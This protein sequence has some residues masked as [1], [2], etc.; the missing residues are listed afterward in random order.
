[1]PLS[2]EP[3]PDPSKVGFDA[4]WV[5]TFLR[6][7]AGE[8]D[9]ANQPVTISRSQYGGEVRLDTAASF[10]AGTFEIKI[11]GLSD[12]DFCTLVH[13]GSPYRLVQIELGWRDLGSGLLAPFASLAAMVRQSG[14]HPQRSLVMVGRIHEARRVTGEF[15]YV[16]EFSGVDYRFHKLS[17][18]KSPGLQ[19][20]EQQPINQYVKQLCDGIIPATLHPDEKGGPI[21]EAAID[22]KSDETVAEALQRL[23]RSAHPDGP[24]REIPMF[25]RSDGLHFGAWTAP[26]A[27]SASHE[28]NLA[29]GLVAS[30]P[31]A[32]RPASQCDVDPFKP[33]QGLKYRL[34]LL[35]RA[36]IQLGDLAKLEPQ[37][38]DVSSTV[39]SSRLGPL[40][41]AVQG[42]ASLFSGRGG[43]PRYKDFRVVGV[44]HKLDPSH[45]F[46]TELVVEPQ[47]EKHTTEDSGAAQAREPEEAHRAAAA[48]VAK[49][50]LDAQLLD[51]GLVNA[52]R[53]KDSGA[54]L[55]RVDVQEGLVATASGNAAVRADRSDT[56]TP[57]RNKPYLTPFAF[58][59]AGLVIPHYPG[60]RVAML[61]LQGLAQQ[62]M[63]AGCLWKEG[64]E[65]EAEYGDWWLCLPTG[66]DPAVS[67]DD[68]R[69]VDPPKGKGSHDLIDAHGGRT[70]NLRGLKVTIGQTL[71]PEVG[72]RPKAASRD[73]LEIEH[74]KSHARI[75]IDKD[76]N[77]EIATEGTLTL[78][79]KRIDAIVQDVME[80]K[81]G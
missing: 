20:K 41:D 16:T 34:T 36:D 12:A 53:V 68:S 33:S 57:L 11:D 21:V 71:M 54:T 81:G 60:M 48:I 70:I 3:G 5:L 80:V 74:E 24:A 56:P 32:E 43:P 9:H 75:A 65:P 55:Q 22:L 76:G 67:V 49:R 79:A 50:R 2:L 51:V 4:D 39:A 66:V 13:P 1:M 18:T 69:K 73:R 61:H 26:A 17:C 59:Q 27:G 62:G 29:T 45:G 23:A 19:L 37:E 25:L 7:T 64:Q 46:A 63:V 35:G 47:P 44:T 31:V 30:K 38:E 15:R 40:G 58:G 10:R 28:L 72:E 52:Q 42:V 77:I 6:E 8:P 78:R 14:N